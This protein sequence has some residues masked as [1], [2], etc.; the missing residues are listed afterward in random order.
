[1]ITA[2]KIAQNYND[3]KLN[4]QRSKALSLLIILFLQE[5]VEKIALNVK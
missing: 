4:T 5:V 1:M 3:T 2:P